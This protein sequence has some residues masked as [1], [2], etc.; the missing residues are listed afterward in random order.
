MEEKKSYKTIF[1]HGSVSELSALLKENTNNIHYLDEENNTV[2]H[3]AIQAERT[4]IIQ[5]LLDHNANAY[6]K[7]KAGLSALDVLMSDVSKYRPMLQIVVDFLKQQHHSS[8]KHLVECKANLEK[9]LTDPD[10]GPSMKK[11]DVKTSLT[12]EEQEDMDDRHGR[13]HR[14]HPVDP[15]SE[16][17][18]FMNRDKERP[19]KQQTRDKSSSPHRNSGNYRTIPCAYYTTLKRCI[20]GDSC[21]FLHSKQYKSDQCPYFME[22]KS[23]SKGSHCPLKHSTYLGHVRFN[24]I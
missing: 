19:R 2:L 6:L 17:S 3:M 9:D 21:T 13:S 16:D 10:I 24:E 7:N 1:S 15:F 5:L 8:Y 14:H 23:C 11:Q 20:N 18:Y 22:Y 4:D 12:K